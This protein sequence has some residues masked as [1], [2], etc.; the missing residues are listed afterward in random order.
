MH[1]HIWAFSFM[2]CQ[3]IEINPVSLAEKK[4]DTPY[5]LSNIWHDAT[6]YTSGDI[7]YNV[8]AAQ[9]CPHFQ[10][11]LYLATQVGHCIGLMLDSSPCKSDVRL[12][13]PSI[14]HFYRWYLLQLLSVHQCAWIKNQLLFVR[15]RNFKEKMDRTAHF[16]FYLDRQIW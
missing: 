3:Q 16:K 15:N 2:T 7:A 8:A 13:H 12:S 1:T 11:Q 14:L 5:Y 9:R 10:A 4:L 6:L